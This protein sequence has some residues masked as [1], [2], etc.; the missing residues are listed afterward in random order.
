[1]KR[2]FFILLPI[3]FL[4]CS[5]NTECPSFPASHR[6]W[7][8]YK[9][10]EQVV[11]ISSS[12]SQMF[13]FTDNYYT[14]AY[15][16]ASTEACDCESE[17]YSRTSIDSV[18]NIKLSCSAR[19]QTIR[20]QFEFE[21]QHFGY[22]NNYYVPVNVDK[23]QFSIKNDGTIENA[24]PIDSMVVENNLFTDILMVETDTISKR[25]TEIYKI[26]IAKNEGIIKYEYKS[27]SVFYLRKL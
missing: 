15:T 22:Q 2:Y 4:S 11:F 12:A 23:F 18:N 16:M 10:N 17:A 1:M 9:T 25:T 20:T 7:F 21:F 6:A 14:R 24:T 27:G 13:V 8:P 19:K 3:I 26:Y 5:K